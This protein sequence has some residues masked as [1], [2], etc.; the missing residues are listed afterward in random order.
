MT[1]DVEATIWSDTFQKLRP[2]LKFA[3]EPPGSIPLATE[4]LRNPVSL[5]GLDVVER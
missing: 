3:F 1:S 4:L 5:H 2:V